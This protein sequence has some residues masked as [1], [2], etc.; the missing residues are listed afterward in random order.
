MSKESTLLK[1]AHS[2]SQMASADVSKAAQAAWLGVL[3]EVRTA[4]LAVA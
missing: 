1:A 4:V 2:G 3:D